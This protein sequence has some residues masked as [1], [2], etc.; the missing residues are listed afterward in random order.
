[1]HHYARMAMG[2]NALYAAEDRFKEGM[3]KFPH[4]PRF[5]QGYIEAAAGR[6]NG[7]E[8]EARLGAA[9]AAFPDNPIFAAR[10][11]EAAMVRRACLTAE[12]RYEEAA[13]LFPDDDVIRNGY[14]KAALRAGHLV[15]A[16][17]QINRALVSDVQSPQNYVILCAIAL[18]TDDSTKK[19][20]LLNRALDGLYE[21]CDPSLR[22]LEIIHSLTYLLRETYPQQYRLRVQQLEGALGMLAASSQFSDSQ[23]APY[24]Q[25]PGVITPEDLTARLY[26]FVNSASVFSGAITH[27]VNGAS[28]RGAWGD[29]HRLNGAPY[30]QTNP[31][32]WNR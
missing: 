6:E 18:R 22:S 4:E 5:Y 19:L 29:G 9:V 12:K 8:V 30:D 27:A 2:R 13:R 32:N 28:A 14:A 25:K 24:Y 11:A 17:E 31:G 20:K 15:L 7:A 21:K 23:L 26:R 1:M 16:E 3:I 10:Y